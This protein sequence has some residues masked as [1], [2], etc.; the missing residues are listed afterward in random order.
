MRSKGANQSEKHISERAPMAC[1]LDG[2]A[3]Q[4][5]GLRGRGG[6]GQRTRLVGPVPRQK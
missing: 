6:L 5:S 4:S 3:G 2:P 1:V